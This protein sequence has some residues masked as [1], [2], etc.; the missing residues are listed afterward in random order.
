MLAHGCSKG[1]ISVKT[2]SSPV[3]VLR[4]F[5]FFDSFSLKFLNSYVLLS[6]KVLTLIILPKNELDGGCGIPNDNFL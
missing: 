2:N 3:A 1:I 4:Y 5:S 6:V